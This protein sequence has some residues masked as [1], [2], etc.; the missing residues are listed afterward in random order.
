MYYDDYGIMYKTAGE[1]IEKVSNKDLEIGLM[2]SFDG[3]EI[4]HHKLLKNSNWVIGP[5]DGW[6]ALEFIYIITGELILTTDSTKLTLKK[7][8]Y[9]QALPVKKDCFFT[10]AVDTEFLYISSQPVFHHY[11]NIIQKFRDL[12]I[13]VEKK[14]GYTADHCSRIMRLSILLGEK[15]NLDTKEL[16]QLNL[17]SFLH[18]IGK[19]K[20]PD[21]V[22]NKPGKLTKQEWRIMKSHPIYGRVILE[23]SSFPSLLEASPIVEQHHERYNGTGYPYGLKKNEILTGAAIIAVADSYDAMT[24]DRVYRKAL[25]KDEAFDEIKKG[26]ETLYHPDV[27]DMFFA[28]EDK[29]A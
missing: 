5:D 11:S 10:A 4:I 25:S 8:D 22:L 3:T 16:Y 20:V 14:D 24:T 7:G 17:G 27:V 21:H 26:K 23:E 1:V 12:A 28:V 18:D 2:A 9:L 19:I 13:E 15:M 29:L 6:S